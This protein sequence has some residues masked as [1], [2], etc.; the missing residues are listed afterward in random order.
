MTN[1][2]SPQNLEAWRDLVTADLARAHA[3]EATLDA[4]VHPQ[5]SPDAPVLSEAVVQGEADGS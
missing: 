3:V 2:L 5:P 4:V 1:P